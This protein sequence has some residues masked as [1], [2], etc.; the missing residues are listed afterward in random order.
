MIP[1]ERLKFYL[2]VHVGAFAPPIIIHLKNKFLKGNEISDLEKKI[3]INFLNYKKE[4]LNIIPSSKE[5]VA[6]L[7]NTLNYVG[8]YILL[9]NKEK[10]PPDT[11]DIF[12][13]QVE[14][15]WDLNVQQEIT[16]EMHQEL[17]FLN[18]LYKKCIVDGI[19]LS[20]ANLVLFENKIKYYL[21]RFDPDRLH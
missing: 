21:R 7:F 15:A 1:E 10:Y 2:S 17:M 13:H 11:P 14:R 16:D 5:I 3:L 19:N 12:V 8:E 4:K 6:S 20:S 18:S 9:Q